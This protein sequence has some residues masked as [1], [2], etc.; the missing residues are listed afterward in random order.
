MGINWIPWTLSLSQ[1]VAKTPGKSVR[2]SAVVHGWL[3]YVKKENS[4][5]G[6][7]YGKACVC[8]CVHTVM[9]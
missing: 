9:C 4:G 5:S 1:E 6:N 8:A 3:P 7:V 2:A